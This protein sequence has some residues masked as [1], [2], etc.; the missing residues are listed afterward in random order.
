MYHS[1]KITTRVIFPFLAMFLLFAAMDTIHARSRAWYIGA[2]TASGTPTGDLNGSQVY[3]GDPVSG[4]FV[5]GVDLEEGDGVAINAG[6]ALNKSIAFEVLYTITSHTATSNYY[7]GETLNADLTAFLIAVRPMLPIGPLEVFGRFGI[8]IY[9][10]KVQGNAEA[11]LGSA[12]QDSSFDGDGYAYG[13]GVAL[14]LGRLGIEA[15]IT[16]HKFSF[17]SLE[18]A[19]NRGEISSIGMKLKTVSVILTLHFGKDLK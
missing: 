14:S 9:N 1:T 18:A 6:F 16:Q 19:G 13:A 12:R 11:P 17:R 3:I 5:F 7:P 2:G 8:G 4:P 15:G 10:L